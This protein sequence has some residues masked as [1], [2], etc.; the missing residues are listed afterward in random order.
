MPLEVYHS[1]FLNGTF[2]L[3]V[4]RHGSHLLIPLSFFLHLSIVK[5]PLGGQFEELQRSV[6]DQKVQIVYLTKTSN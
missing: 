6:R 4:S 1:K 3:V 2:C 5:G